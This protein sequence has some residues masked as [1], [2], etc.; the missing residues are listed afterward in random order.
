MN[1]KN[2]FTIFFCFCISFVFAQPPA[3]VPTEG[4]LAWWG[5][6]DATD[7]TTNGN[8]L[9]AFGLTS[10]TDRFGITNAAYSFNGTSSYLTRSSIG[11]TFTQ[12]G[13]FSV[14][15][16]IKKVNNVTGNVAIMSGTTTSL[17]FIWLVQCDATK[18]IFGTNKQ[19]SAWF[20][21]NAS[22]NYVINEWEHYVG[23]YTANT[24]TFY[25]NG[26]LQ[27]TTTNTHTNVN[28]AILPIWIGRGVSGNYFNGSLDDIGIWNRALTPNEIT[29]LYQSTLSV[30]A[31]TAVNVKVY[32][33]PASDFLQLEVDAQNIG[34]NYQIID[35]LG[36][37][38]ATGVMVDT[39]TEISIAT[40]KSGLYFLKMGEQTPIK[41]MKN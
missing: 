23:V 22:T 5:M 34:E 13:S 7:A 28:Q 26:F 12:A 14:S 16:W 38:V 20:W 15:I 39:A 25:R 31:F 8:T 29:V 37:I 40:L 18:A 30:D 27:G 35:D 3:Y 32:P 19:Q 24:M 17:N 11:H 36:R 21:T 6:A 33:N 1:L 10:T 4:L 2:Y 41:F 9:T